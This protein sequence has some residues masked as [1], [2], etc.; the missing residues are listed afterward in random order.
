[1][2][3]SKENSGK[4]ILAILKYKLREELKKW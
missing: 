3:V 2:F 4:I 1:M